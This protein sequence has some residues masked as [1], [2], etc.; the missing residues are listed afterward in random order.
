MLCGQNT[1]LR[2]VKPERVLV[3]TT[4][5]QRVKLIRFCFC[6][7]DAGSSDFV[8]PIITWFVLHLKRTAEKTR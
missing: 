2:N 1:E 5:F 3:V 4:G 8:L 7:Q 6:G